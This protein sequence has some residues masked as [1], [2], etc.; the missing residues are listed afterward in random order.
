METSGMQVVTTVPSQTSPPCNNRGNS[1][2]GPTAVGRKFP[3]S[4]LVRCLLR[5]G[6][7]F[8]LLSNF[9]GGSDVPPK[10]PSLSQ[11]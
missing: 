1:L 7:S 2:F 8:G 9:Q 4:G 6:F 11:N 5:A 10:R 3:T